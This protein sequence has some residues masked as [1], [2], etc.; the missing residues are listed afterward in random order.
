MIRQVSKF[1]IERIARYKVTVKSINAI[2]KGQFLEILQK[3]KK[4]NSII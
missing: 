3:V 1:C 4:K 2:V